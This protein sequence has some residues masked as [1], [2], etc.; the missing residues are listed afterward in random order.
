MQGSRTEGEIGICSLPLR[1]HP[2]T[3]ALNVGSLQARYA[4]TK[5]KQQIYVAV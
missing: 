1:Q 4:R 3:K 2:S 5:T